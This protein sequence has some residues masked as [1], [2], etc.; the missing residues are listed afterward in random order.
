MKPIFNYILLAV[1]TL[2]IGFALGF[3]VSGRFTKDRIERLKSFYTE[4]GFHREFVR[5]LDPTPE[6]L[7]KIK[8][9]LLKHSELNQDLLL[10]HREEQ[11]ILLH[12]LEEELSPYLTEAQ[13]EKL[14][15]VDARRGPH[16]Q[17]RWRGGER[18]G[19]NW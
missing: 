16:N 15:H 4:Q 6:Q 13:L 2:L 8:P 14:H 19:R 10:R 11:Q 1:L 5:L 7:Q 17:K 18:K 3:I 9:I 12:E